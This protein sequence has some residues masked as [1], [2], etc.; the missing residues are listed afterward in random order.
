MKAFSADEGDDAGS[1]CFHCKKE[2]PPETWFARI[3]LGDSRILFCRPRCLE[4]Y[5][6]KGQPIKT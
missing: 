5:L 2:I 6:E 1:R 4:V 3:R